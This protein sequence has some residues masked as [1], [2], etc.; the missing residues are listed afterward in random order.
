MR[1]VKT[2]TARPRFLAIHE[3]EYRVTFSHPHAPCFWFAAHLLVPASGY[4]EDETGVVRMPVF[5][6]HSVI[7]AADCS[8]DVE[9]KLGTPTD[10]ASCSFA[11]DT[12]S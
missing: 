8:C 2:L 1:T 3:G 11:P 4:P 9:R 6:E 10:L 12:G 5:A 7:V